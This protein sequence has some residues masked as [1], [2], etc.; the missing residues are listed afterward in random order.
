MDDWF[1]FQGGLVAMGLLA[2]VPGCKDPDTDTTT[3]NTTSSEPG[4]TGETGGTSMSSGTGDTPTG[5]GSGSATGTTGDAEVPPVCVSYAAKLAECNIDPDP[6]EPLDH[7]QTC[8]MILMDSEVYGADCVQ[9]LEAFYS[10]PTTLSCA[11]L[12]GACEAE[13]AAVE[14]ACVPQVPPV[15][16]PYGAKAAECLMEPEA[17]MAYEQMCAYELMAYSTYYGPACADAAESSMAC[18]SGLSCKDFLGHLMDDLP[19]CEAEAAAK[20]AACN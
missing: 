19:V 16:V 6:G 14:A 9:A 10:C 11:E 13:M 7:E 5:S 18:L 8:A 12:V 20:A 4:S 1:G 3:G 17:A 2:A 15:C